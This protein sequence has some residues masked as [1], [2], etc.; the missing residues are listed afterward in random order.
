MGVKIKQFN[1][2]VRGLFF[3][4]SGRFMLRKYS[5]LRIASLIACVSSFILLSGIF[6]PFNFKR[7]NT[8]AASQSTLPST[9]TFTSVSDN[10]TVSINPTSTGVFGKSAD[11]SSIKFNITTN[12]CS[13]YT[14]SARTSRTTLVNGSS[15][16]SSL[17]SSVSESQ[18]SNASNTTLNNRWGY[19]PNYYN[20]SSNSNFLPSPGT[21]STLDHTTAANSTA[22]N[23]TIVL[24]ARVNTEVPAGTYVNDTLILEATANAVPYTI[25]FNK[26]AD[27][28]IVSN[29]PSNKTGE[30][31]SAN[32]VTL[33]STVPTRVNYTF[34]GWCTTI[35]VASAGGYMI[36][37]STS[38]WITQTTTCT[39]SGLLLVVATKLLPPLAPAIRILML[40]V[41][42]TLTT[43]LLPP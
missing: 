8:E 18:F 34:A 19:K 21:S 27:D 4:N 17:A 22:K 28:D 26:A 20:S 15:S 6:T 23:Y 3:D 33:P 25:K 41:C 37:T 31:V 38:P 11:D 12:N 16:L 14:L 40:S 13:G 30:S 36:T 5:S 32:N 1:V 35:P 29:M 7:V 43:L 39:P 10:A 42:R 24:G 2:F 9:I